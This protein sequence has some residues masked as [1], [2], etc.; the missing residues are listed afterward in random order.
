MLPSGQRGELFEAA[1][2]H[3]LRLRQALVHISG[4]IRNQAVSLDFPALAEIQERP[5]DLVRETA[6]LIE[7]IAPV[8]RGNRRR[9]AVVAVQTDGEIVG[10]AVNRQQPPGEIERSVAEFK[11]AV[12]EIFVDSLRIELPGAAAH[13]QRRG[14]QARVLQTL[15]IQRR[16]CLRVEFDDRSDDG[17]PGAV[18]VA[19]VAGPFDHD[20][21]ADAGHLGVMVRPADHGVHSRCGELVVPRARLLRQPDVRGGR[22]DFLRNLQF[23]RCGGGT[24]GQQQGAGGEHQVSVHSFPHR[25]SAV[26]RERRRHGLRRSRGG[27]A[28]LEPVRHLRKT[29][30]RVIRHMSVVMAAFARPA[31]HSFAAPSAPPELA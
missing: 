10:H 17:L 5:D 30:F 2:R 24:G 26:L 22:V 21:V 28:F 20:P 29:F 23:D 15:R 11:P 9:N 16:A 8:L 4:R 14:R 25:S 3:L 1:L 27:D 7:F 19:E 31:C 18:F 13:R 12:A 6:L